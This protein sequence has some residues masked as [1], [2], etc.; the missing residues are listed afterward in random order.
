[1]AAAV[2]AAVAEEVSL[3]ARQSCLRNQLA[4]PALA[5][6]SLGA[7]VATRKMV[8]QLWHG[9]TVAVQ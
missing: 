8:A 3:V 5:G 2:A 9:Q 7:V 1:M 6:C 4:R